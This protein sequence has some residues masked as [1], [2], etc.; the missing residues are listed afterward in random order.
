MKRANKIL[1][2][3]I[4]I[5]MVLSLLPL[6]AFA[7]SEFTDMPDKG[8]WSYESLSAAVQKGL[9]QG[10]NGKLNPTN[11]LKRAE[12]AT[13]VSRAFNATKKADIA[14]Y[15]DVNSTDWFAPYIASAVQMQT[16]QGDGAGKIRPED[17]ITRQEAFAVL[18]RAF[19]LSGGSAS[20]LNL[21]TDKSKVANWAIDPLASMAAAG[22]IKGSGGLLRPT[23][24]ITR[25]EFSSVMYNMLSTYI[26]KAGIYTELTVG[27]VMVNAADVILKD[28]TVKGDLIIGDGVGNGDVTLDNTTVT[29]RLVVRGGGVNSIKIIGN[30]N[31]QNIIV[32]RVDGQVRVFAEDGT[33]IGA[34][35]VDGSDDV[36][37][38][39][40][41]GTVT[42]VADDATVTAISA[43]ITN[44]TIT[45]SDSKI[46]VDSKSKAENITV[47]GTNATITA[48]SG[49][50]IDK[51]EVNGTGA[52]INGSG[53]VTSVAANANNATVTTTGT[54]VK[55]AE[56]TTGVTAGDKPVEAGTE[57]TVTPPP[58]TG[59]VPVVVIPVDT[60][61][62]TSNDTVVCGQTLQLTADVT[63][64]NATNKTVIWSV[65]DGSTLPAGSTL[66][67]TGAFAA[68]N[69]TGSVDVVAT[70]N[71]GIKGEATINVVVGI[72]SIGKAVWSKEAPN[73]ESI[74]TFMDE[75]W[76]A[77]TGV[78][79]YAD[80]TLTV[81]IANITEDMLTFINANLDGDS[82]PV[83]L[84]MGGDVADTLTA[85]ADWSNS[86]VDL[87]CLNVTDN[88][89]IDRNVGTNSEYGYKVEYIGGIASKIISIEKAVFTRKDNPTY[90]HD[91][92][93]YLDELWAA[94]TGVLSYANGKVTVNLVNITDELFSL[95]Y[96]FGITVPVKVVFN[97]DIFAE[98]FEPNSFFDNSYIIVISLDETTNKINEFQV[99]AGRTYLYTV[100]Y[101]GASETSVTTQNELLSALNEAGVGTIQVNGDVELTESLYIR[102]GKLINL[103]ES[104]SITV[105]NEHSVEIDGIMVVNTGAQII[106][107][108]GI[109]VAPTGTLRTND[110][111]GIVNNGQIVLVSELECTTG[112]KVISNMVTTSYLSAPN[113]R[114]LGG[115]R[116]GIENGAT[117]I[118]FGTGLKDS[119]Y[120]SFD[121]K[122]FTYLDAFEGDYLIWIGD[123]W[124][125]S[126]T[127]L[128]ESQLHNEQGEY[129]LID[130][131]NSFYNLDRV[132]L[133]NPVSGVEKEGITEL[134]WLTY[135][136]YVNKFSF[137]ESYIVLNSLDNVA[138]EYGKIMA[139]LRGD[140]GENID[141][142]D[143]KEEALASYLLAAARLASTSTESGYTIVDEVPSIKELYD[144][145]KV[146]VIEDPD[147]G[148][149]ILVSVDIIN[150]IDG[151]GI[152][153]VADFIALVN[154][155]VAG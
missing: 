145:G 154:E 61:T 59:S 135:Y 90:E 87:I 42:V 7:T 84:L 122:E 104:S 17:P 155:A 118:N 126:L 131:L 129:I 102:R 14:A 25:E 80:G 8:H 149:S 117:N 37:I 79:A 21:F 124:V 6:S 1:S 62:V 94:D 96:N 130:V 45:G 43:T 100:E 66:S 47:S 12:M 35:I 116:I 140:T 137:P 106:N 101:V 22:Y 110:P 31:V 11:K 19:K 73:V 26:T 88:G 120:T 113:I 48:N 105:P 151:S 132:F 91:F 13:I 54:V 32:A 56:G 146:V 4:A 97:G 3:A 2:L 77:D 109:L 127:L 38:E 70:T 92:N 36:I 150:N 65:K 44:A 27:N 85:D 138:S 16:F 93:A 20:T 125:R 108:G 75:L 78:L 136:D 52:T 33:E 69:T 24:H 23:D 64:T 51:V 18:A 121:G 41:V 10:S 144:S 76:A 82:V 58:A 34:V 119:G 57:Q 112:G 46:V 67:A 141:K 142:Y 153:S 40:V 68:G 148:I 115:G 143:S 111:E 39:G 134:F 114:Y 133:P 55:A 60:I 99:N 89:S 98:H 9:L 29:G 81:N 71:N 63:P 139:T 123:M 5:V 74:N 15:V 147:L 83:K 86:F 72:I 152:T 95:I 50:T 28:V 128:K 107:N 53:K 49:A 30:S 103:T